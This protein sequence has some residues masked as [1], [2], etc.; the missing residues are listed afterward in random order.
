MI[1][2]VR[3]TVVSDEVLTSENDS[4]ESDSEAAMTQKRFQVEGASVVDLECSLG[5]TDLE[6]LNMQLE[7]VFTPADSNATKM[8]PCNSESIQRV[9]NWVVTPNMNSNACHLKIMNFSKA[10]GGQYDCLM[11]LNNSHTSYN[12]DKS[13][14]IFLAIKNPKNQDRKLLYYVIPSSIA[15]IVI[16]CLVIFVIVKIRKKLKHHPRPDVPALGMLLVTCRF[17]V[18]H[19]IIIT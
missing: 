6:H 14:A 16:L 10:D 3:L 1:T 18:Q 5:L 12:Q 8:V 19:I 2:D 4:L 11:V 7:F 9:D 17:Y 13:N 15:A